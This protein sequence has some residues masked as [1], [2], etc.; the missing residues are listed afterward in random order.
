MAI[1]SIA[2]VAGTVWWSGH[3]VFWAGVAT[4]LVSGGLLAWTVRFPVL[5]RVW[6]R[7]GYVFGTALVVLLVASTGGADSSYQDM[8]LVVPVASALSLS[9]VGF[10]ASVIA[11]AV[12]AVLPVV[13]D[14]AGQAFVADT[15][16]DVAVWTGASTPVLL[17]TRYARR[18]EEALRRANEIKSAF[19][20]AVSHELRTPMTIISGIAK[21][22]HRRGDRLTGRDLEALIGGLDRNAARLCRLV[23]DLLDVDRLLRGTM[24]LSPAVV[25]LA[26]V[27]IG[28]LADLEP[29]GRILRLDAR[30]ALASMDRPKMER[31]VEHLVVNALRH[32]PYEASIWITVGRDEEA[33]RLT[34]ED[35]GPGVPDGLKARVFRPFEQ[36]PESAT[37]AAPGTGLGLTLVAQVVEA[38]GGTVRVEDRPGGGARFCLELPAAGG[39]ERA[40]RA[41]GSPGAR[42]S[43]G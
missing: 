4:V 26:D 23:T 37:A 15:F 7:L 6:D 39:A 30:P 22:L 21:T 33:V 8:F 43:A 2:A 14:G 41:P 19:L 1:G 34:V 11:A 9:P 40:P 32:T 5:A 12:G 27:T 24:M 35:D 42:T 20:R 28:V 17:L 31:A 16:A 36:G 29:G 3:E 13:Y 38:H 18:Q 10:A 25:D